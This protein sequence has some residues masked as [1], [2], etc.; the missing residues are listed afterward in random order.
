MPKGNL[1]VEPEELKLLKAWVAQGANFDGKNPNASLTSFRPARP[2]SPMA[3]A[4]DVA[5][6]ALTG[7]E[8]VSFA[9][10]VAPILLDN[11]AECHIADNRRTNFSMSSL[12]ALLRGGDGGAVLKPGDSATSEIVL[13]LSLIHISEPTRPY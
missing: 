5:S 10:H 1:K 4:A 3:P 6:M 9:V 13:R 12:A 8:T 11:C 2:K 7:K